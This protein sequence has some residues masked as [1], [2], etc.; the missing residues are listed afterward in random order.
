MITRDVPLTDQYP[1][2]VLV[3]YL[4]SYRLPPGTKL[5]AKR[6]PKHEEFVW[7]F[8]CYDPRTHTT[9]HFKKSEVHV[10][11]RRQRRRLGRRM[12]RK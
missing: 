3:R 7:D 2:V 1:L 12:G 6:M 11:T 8:E 10:V 4:S 9:Y 5:L